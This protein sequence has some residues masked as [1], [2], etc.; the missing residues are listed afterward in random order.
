MDKLICLIV[1]LVV[2]LATCSR[3][4]EFLISHWCGPTEATPEKIKEAAGANF[5]VIMFG[6]TVNENKKALDLCQENRVKALIVDSR[7]MAKRSRERDFAANLDAVIADYG[8]HPALWGY[9]LMDEPNSSDFRRLAPVSKY[10]AKKD[11]GHVPYINLFP[12]YATREQ[13]G[14]PTYEQHV[15]EFCRV[16]QPKLVSYDHYALLANGERPDYFENLEIIR[17]Q[18]IKHRV[19]FNYILLSVPHGPYREP[20]EADLRWQVNTALAYGARGLMYFTYTTPNDPVWNYRNAIIDSE[21][22]PTAKYDQVRRI[23]GEILELAPTLMRLTSVAVY[24]TGMAPRGAKLLPDNGL[25]A[26]I[27]GGEFVVGQF[28]SDAGHKYA[29][30]VNRSPRQAARAAVTFSQTVE[31]WEVSRSTGRERSVFVSDDGPGSTWRAA[32]KPGEGRLV[33]IETPQ[34]LPVLHWDDTPKFRPRVMLNP[35]CQFG[36]VIHGPDEQELYNEG[37]NM[38]DIAL[39]VRDDLARD[40]RIDCF[41]SRS[42]REQDVSLRYETALTRS[43]NCDA[44]VSLHSD[45]TGTDDPGGGTWTFYADEGEG[46]RLAE[47][48][49]TPLLEA[50]RSFYPE[51]QFRGVRTHWYRLWVLWESGCPASLTE[52][53]FHTNP[54][55]REM[56]KDPALQEIMA[57]AIAGGI[58][59]YFGLK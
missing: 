49:Q 22:K 48:V 19:P 45:A 1:L 21:G 47:C 41:V 53:L 26:H 20:S 38:Y 43:L 44:L 18:G 27:D 57:R 11:P 14:N 13:L 35:S 34:D 6:G 39:K 16:V 42:S 28:N 29:M 54:K 24:H 56:L 3:A 25:I 9:Y 31:L 50:I 10:L 58:L 59:D 15:D 4:D 32:F 40:G 46:K 12:T 2:A 51:V 37:L 36:N 5:N 17:R 33:R 8:S 55:E 30:L 7:A 52:V 23:N